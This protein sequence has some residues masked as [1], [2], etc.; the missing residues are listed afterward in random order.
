MLL[1]YSVKSSFVED[2]KNGIKIHTIREDNTDRWK[3]G[4]S[5]HHWWGNPRNPRNNPYCFLENRCV[6]TQKIWIY[7]FEFTD[8]KKGFALHLAIEIDDIPID[9]TRIEILVQNDGLTMEE[10]FNYFTPQPNTTFEGKI[11]H[12]T[13]LRY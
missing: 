3:A 6:S 9:W 10:F 2:I 4:R 7:R 13:D 11:I 5:I 12:W 1:T 8:P